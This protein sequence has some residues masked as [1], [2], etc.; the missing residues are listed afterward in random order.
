MAGFQHTYILGEDR[1]LKDV[2]EAHKMMVGHSSITC[3]NNPTDKVMR[4]LY[5]TGVLFY[6]VANKFNKEEEE[7]GDNQN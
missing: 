4:D 6:Q 5:T 1:C 3:N 7:N 2:E